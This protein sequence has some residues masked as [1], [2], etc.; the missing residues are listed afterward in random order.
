MKLSEFSTGLESLNEAY[1]EVTDQL[2]MEDSEANAGFRD[3]L[4]IWWEALSPDYEF[5]STYEES[6][7]QDKKSID[8]H[9]NTVEQLGNVLRQRDSK[10]IE[11][12]SAYLLDTLQKYVDKVA[13]TARDKAARVEGTG[14]KS[15]ASKMRDDHRRTLL[16]ATRIEQADLS[17]RLRAAVKEARAAAKEAQGAAES[18]KIA[19]GVAS[20]A[21]LTKRFKALSKQQLRT[22]TQFRWLT[23]VCVLAGIVGTYW[24]AFGAGVSHPAETTTGDAI[25]RV[26]LLGAV[27]G[28]ATYFGRQAGYHRDLGT[29]AKTIEEQLLTFDGYMEPVHDETIRDGMRAAFAARVFGSSP[30]S[31]DDSGVTLGSSFISELLAAVGK[32]GANAAK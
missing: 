21:E 25:I 8:D 31:K 10:N 32:S 7:L 14:E 24:I 6:V 30:D 22:A 19:A 20:G 13:Q 3:V 5:L 12:W 18:A 28:L 9:E 27:L 15:E 23:A 11:L 26:S 29:W 2:R 4:L 16:L 1:R 17:Q